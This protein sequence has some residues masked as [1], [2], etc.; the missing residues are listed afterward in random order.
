MRSHHGIAIVIAVLIITGNK[1]LRSHSKPSASTRRV[2]V[3]E[4]ALVERPPLAQRCEAAGAK[5]RTC[6]CVIQD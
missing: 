5:K 6:R 4:S 2:S 1:E 3:R